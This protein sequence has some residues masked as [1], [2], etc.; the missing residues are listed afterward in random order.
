MKFLYHVQ[1]VVHY[2]VDW[3]LATVKLI[4]NR[5]VGW[6]TLD[7]KTG[8]IKREQQPICKKLKLWILFSRPIE[9]VDRTQLMRKWIHDKSIKAGKEEATKSSHDQIKSFVEFYGINMNDFTPSNIEEYGSFED[10]FVRK[11]TEESRPVFDQSDPANAVVVADSRLVVYD[12]VDQSKRLWIKG[13]HFTIGNLIGDDDLANSWHDGAIASFRLSPQDYHRYHCPVNGTVEWFKRMPGE[14][15]QVDPL[16]LRSNIDILTSNARCA[17]CINS[18]VWKGV[19]CGS[20]SNGCWNGGNQR[21]VP[22]SRFSHAKGRG[23]WA[24]PVWRLKYRRC[25]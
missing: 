4:Q 21:E 22:D 7:R 17:L 18:R 10:F 23:D 20:W 3:L 19:V 9:W 2:A 16:C 12:S 14:Y 1:S 8:R 25:L 15:Y 24:L 13:K 11:H 5:E 6:K